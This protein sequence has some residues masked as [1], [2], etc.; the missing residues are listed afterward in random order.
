MICVTNSAFDRV[1]VIVEGNHSLIRQLLLTPQVD[2]ALQTGN[3]VKISLIKSYTNSV[4]LDYRAY[5]YLSG[6]P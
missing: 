3:A 5:S 4:Y 1:G 2:P 6:L